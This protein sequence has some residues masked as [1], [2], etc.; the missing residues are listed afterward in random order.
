MPN[1]EVRAESKLSMNLQRQTQ[2]MSQHG[3]SLSTAA[4]SGQQL[5]LSKPSRKKQQYLQK[6]QLKNMPQNALPIA[7]SFVINGA[8]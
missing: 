5:Q 8:S 7:S 6:S 1:V 2:S 4:M 3:K